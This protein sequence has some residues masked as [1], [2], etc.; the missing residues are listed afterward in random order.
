MI[1]ACP[2]CGSRM[3]RTRLARHRCRRGPEAMPVMGRR[4]REFRRALGWSQADLATHLRKLG[5][6]CSR[7]MV[8]KL[9]W[10]LRVP[11][12]RLAKAIRRIMLMRGYAPALL[13][14]RMNQKVEPRHYRRGWKQRWLA[15]VHEGKRTC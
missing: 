8:D 13:H 3:S 2:K 6:R 1:V 5:Y 12:F 9:E 15:E 11:S 10:Q 14:P 4:L 7:S